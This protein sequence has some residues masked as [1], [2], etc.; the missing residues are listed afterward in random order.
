MI[1]LIFVP[2]YLTRIILFLNRYVLPG[3][4]NIGNTFLAI[5][6]MD[7]YTPFLQIGKRG[8][9]KMRQIKLWKTA[10]L[11]TIFLFLPLP[12]FRDLDVCI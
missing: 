9:S 5:Y 3:S 8:K 4:M 10:A 6:L 12:L 2:N 11:L 1:L 7:L